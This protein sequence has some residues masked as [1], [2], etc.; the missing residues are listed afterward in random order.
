ME[1]YNGV[2]V[3]YGDKTDYMENY[4]KE[5]PLSPE[6]YGD[7]DIEEDDDEAAAVIGSIS[8]IIE[9]EDAAQEILDN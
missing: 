7:M 6:I 2:E 5:A 9:I 8:T 3:D 1:L 4:G